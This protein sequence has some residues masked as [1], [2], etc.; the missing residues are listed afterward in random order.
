MY[1][2]IIKAKYDKLIINII[3]NSEILK[4]KIKN[5]TRMPTLTGPNKHSTGSPSQNNQTR[6][7]KGIR[8]RNEE[9]KWSLFA[10]DMIYIKNSK[11]STK[12][13]R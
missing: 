10:D 1:L 3:L 6:K 8:I 7:R 11:D 2:S 12:K 13:L 4:A 9:V 5:K